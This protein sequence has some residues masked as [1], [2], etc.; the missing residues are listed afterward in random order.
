MAELVDASDSK[1]GVRKD[2]QVRFLFWALGLSIVLWKVAKV[3]FLNLPVIC[4]KSKKAIS[5]GCKEL[6]RNTKSHAVAFL[7]KLVNKKT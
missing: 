7:A 1:S 2:V 5:Q 6:F 3:T 4:S